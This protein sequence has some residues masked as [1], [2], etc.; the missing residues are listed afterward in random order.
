MTFGM[1]ILPIRISK[2]KKE[3]GN[4]DLWVNMAGNTDFVTSNTEMK[5][6]TEG[7]QTSRLLNLRLVK[8]KWQHFYY[9]RHLMWRCWTKRN[10]FFC[11]TLKIS[12]T[13][14][15]SILDIFNIWYLQLLDDWKCLSGFRFRKQ[16][17]ICLRRGF[18]LLD[19]IKIYTIML[20]QPLRHFASYLGG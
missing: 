19:I 11:Y 13:G 16:G 6:M 2:S 17:I 18:W 9:V 15:V 12:I 5:V 4:F 3:T 7:K 14:Q 10:F 1:D 20:F 8:M